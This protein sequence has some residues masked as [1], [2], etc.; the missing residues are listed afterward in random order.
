VSRIDAETGLRW[1]WYLMIAGGALVAIGALMLLAG[2]GEPEGGPRYT[3]KDGWESEPGAS[4]TLDTSERGGVFIQCWY[5]RDEPY[6]VEWD[7]ETMPMLTCDG[8]TCKG[9]VTTDEENGTFADRYESCTH[10]PDMDPREICDENHPG[11]NGPTFERESKSSDPVRGW[12]SK[13]SAIISADTSHECG[14]D[15]ALR[16]WRQWNDDG[17]QVHVCCRE[18]P[19]ECDVSILRHDGRRVTFTVPGAWDEYH[20]RTLEDYHYRFGKR[21]WEAGE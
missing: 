8:D 11:W 6:C 7:V 18:E 20:P 2:W 5:G 17:E 4:V 14:A 21:G 19:Q 3:T 10:T 12:E 16:E 1:S 9:E 15:T 13:P